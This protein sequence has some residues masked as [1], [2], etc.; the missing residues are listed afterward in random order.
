MPVPT[1]P[2]QCWE[3]KSSTG[4]HFDVLDGLR[5]IAILMVVILHTFYVNETRSVAE[6]VLGYVIPAG[7]VGVPIFFVLSGFLISLPFFTGRQAN[8]DFWYPKGYARRRLAKIMPP[9][10]LSILFFAVFYWF[11]FHDPAYL[12]EIGRAHV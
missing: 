10:Y 12:N 4:N 1:N 3:I 11:R 9:F 6:W 7:W 2:A 8:A 5:G